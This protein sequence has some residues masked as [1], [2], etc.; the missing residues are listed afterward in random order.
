MYMGIN[1]YELYFMSIIKYQCKAVNHFTNIEF[2]NLLFDLKEIYNTCK[3]LFFYW[4]FI[5]LINV[6]F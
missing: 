1:Y 4:T 6:Y 5:K 2:M 3:I